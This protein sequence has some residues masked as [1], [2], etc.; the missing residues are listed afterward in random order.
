MQEEQAKIIRSQPR[1][2][3]LFENKEGFSKRIKLTAPYITDTKRY[4]KRAMDSSAVEGMA[5]RLESEISSYSVVPHVGATASG[6]AG[7]QESL[8]NRRPFWQKSFL[9][10]PLSY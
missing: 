10:R 3:G 8:W 7:S 5:N 2:K 1:F 4:V 9:L 6:S